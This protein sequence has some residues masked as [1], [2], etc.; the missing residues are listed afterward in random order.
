[1]DQKDG[2][3]AAADEDDAED[4]VHDEDVPP[5]RSRYHGHG[6]RNEE[7]K[8]PAKTLFPPIFFSDRARHHDAADL[9]FSFSGRCYKHQFTFQPLSWTLEEETL[10][11]GFFKCT[12]QVV[13]LQFLCLELESSLLNF[14]NRKLIL[15]LGQVIL[16]I[17]VLLK[18]TSL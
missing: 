7:F 12:R 18:L 2:E 4:D 8:F 9:E 6:G 15:P 14:E 16:D 5:K 11:D 10:G 17:S 13:L 1:M 3:A